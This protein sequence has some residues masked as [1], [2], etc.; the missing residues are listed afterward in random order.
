MRPSLRKKPTL[1]PSSWVAGQ[2][3]L[4]VCGKGPPNGV[5]L[6]PGVTECIFNENEILSDQRERRITGY[7]YSLDRPLDAPRLAVEKLAKRMG[8]LQTEQERALSEASREKEGLTRNLSDLGCRLDETL[9]KLRTMFEERDAGRTLGRL[10]RGY[11]APIL[12]LLCGIL[13]VS[14]VG[15]AGGA[16]LA[17]HLG[18]R[19]GAGLSPEMTTTAVVSPEWTATVDQSPT[20]AFTPT[21]ALAPTETPTPTRLASPTPT[22]TRTATSAPTRTPTAATRPTFTAT[23]LPLAEVMVTTANVRAGPGMTCDV[24]VRLHRGDKI[25]VVARTEDGSWFRVQVV[26]TAMDGWIAADLIELYE[27]MDEIP[28]VTGD[29]LVP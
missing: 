26:T 28:I 2:P 10:W 17:M 15:G 20:K 23:S 24:L 14:T 12:L 9:V 29:Q 1:F 5:G 6:P 19:L 25:Q 7:Q 13:L 18:P 22:T 11:R 27:A 8:T 4:A 16:Y 3:L 21:M